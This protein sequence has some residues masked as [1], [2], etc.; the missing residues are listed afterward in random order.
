M[1][2][3]VI[4]GGCECVEEMK[5]GWEVQ[6]WATGGVGRM[7]RGKGNTCAWSRGF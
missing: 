3:H 5:V 2:Q 1:G 7:E 4:N 6:S